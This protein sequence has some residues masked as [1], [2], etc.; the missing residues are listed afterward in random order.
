MEYT[1]I[2]NDDYECPYCHGQ[3]EDAEDDT[4]ICKN[5]G[6]Q[7]YKFRLYEVV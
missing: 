2:P 7:G 5:E 4:R 6:C 1:Y 3:L